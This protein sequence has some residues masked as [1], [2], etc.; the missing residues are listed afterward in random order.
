LIPLLEIETVD[1][2]GKPKI[3]TINCTIPAAE[4]IACVCS[5]IPFRK[6]TQTLSWIAGIDVDEMTALRATNYIAERFV[7]KPPVEIAVAEI[8]KATEK[9]KDNILKIRVNQL[10]SHENG[11]ERDRIVQLA[12]KN[13]PEGVY[14]KD[15]EGPKIKVMFLG[16]DGTGVPGIRKELAGVKGKQADGSAKTFEAKIGVAFIVEYTAD[17]RPLLKENGELYR[18]REVK[19]TGTIRKV[20]EFGP[21][22]YRFAVENGMND[23]DAIVFLGDGAKWIW[24]IQEK[25]FPQALTAVDQYHAIERL[26]SMIDF[27][28][29]KGRMG[30]DKKKEFKEKCIELLRQ[31][32]IQV[33]L[34]LIDSIPCM[35]N[36]KEALKQAKGYFITNMDRMNYGAFTACGIYV[37]SGVV[38]SGCK[39]IVGNRMKC[40]GMHWSKKNAEKMIALR[41]SIRN[42]IFYEAFHYN[43]ETGAK[44]AA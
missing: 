2:D 17:G 16:D 31:G 8:E 34:D 30:A 11:D 10:I 24:N 32:K 19:Y 44:K 22:L 26:N 39:V 9:T 15:Y 42:D 13:G 41:C 43:G 20:D 18:D 4:K 25:Y 36:K 6:A 33:I 40:G 1:K 21:M 37:G 7:E 29:F 23:V 3:S 28:C 27:L 35:P 14:Y 5:D 38:E 12:I